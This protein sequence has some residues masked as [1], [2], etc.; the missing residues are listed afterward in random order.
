[1]DPRFLW[2]EMDFYPPLAALIY[3]HTQNMFIHAILLKP[4]KDVWFFLFVS[5]RCLN[6]NVWNLCSSVQTGAVDQPTRKYI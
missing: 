1:M 6:S 3:L 2:L 4:E 5:R